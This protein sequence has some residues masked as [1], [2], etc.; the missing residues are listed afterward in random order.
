MIGIHEPKL[1]KKTFLNIEKCLTS[2]WVSTSGYFLNSVSS[3]LKNY[4]KIK[5]SLLTNSGTSALD[6]AIRVMEFEK[7]TIILVPSITFIAPI[8]AVIY[9]HCE[10]YLFDC[11]EYLN[12]DLNLMEKFL[13]KNVI[14]KKVKN[15]KISFHKKTKQ[16]IGAVI[17]THVFGNAVNIYRLKR[18]CKK[19]NIKIIEDASESLGTRYITGFLKNKFT[20]T[21]GDIGCFSFNGNKIITSGSGGALVTN[22][23]NYYEK[24]KHLAFQSK[25]DKNDYK[26]DE[27]G[28]NYGM[29]NLSAALLLD[30]LKR[31]EKIIKKK[32]TISKFYEEKINHP[33]FEVLDSPKYARNNKWLSVLRVKNLT[34]KQINNITIKFRK[35][36]IQLRKVWLP[37]YYNN[38][39]KNFYVNQKINSKNYFTFLCLPS[40]EFLKINTLK[41]ICKLFNKK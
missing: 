6:L 18:I 38:H 25:K 1:T 39:L 24:A 8:N 28:F 41:K 40:S 9:N 35:K 22:N 34:K 10:P 33:N 31:I 32:I 12:F 11:D 27:L 14:I 29:T 30:Q 17:I 21:I 23:K 4:L 26:H 15:L 19:Y 2:N 36:N 13:K 7:K 3:S 16:R 5:Y 20:G 37:N